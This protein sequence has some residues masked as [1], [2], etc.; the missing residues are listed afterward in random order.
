MTPLIADFYCSHF[1]LA[2]SNTFTSLDG[3]RPAF[4][5]SSCRLVPGLQHGGL[6]G[7]DP[8]ENVV[9]QSWRLEEIVGVGQVA[10]ACRGGGTGIVTKPNLDPL[11]QWE[12]K[13]V[14]W[15]VVKES[16][17]FIA[18]HPAWGQARR[19]GSSGSKDLNCLIA[20]GQG[21]LKGRL[22]VP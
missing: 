20:F 18:R 17:A 16:T 22:R 11:A 4:V 13:P 7:T 1:N 19:K 5:S 3:G 14:Y 10:S 6:T 2:T 21:V 15:V 8:G 12:A 9:P